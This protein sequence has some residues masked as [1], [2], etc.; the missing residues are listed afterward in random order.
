MKRGQRHRNSNRGQEKPFISG[1]NGVVECLKSPHVWVS[2]IVFEREIPEPVKEFI[3]S[4][5][6]EKLEPDHAFGQLVQQVGCLIK[7]PRWPALDELVESEPFKAVQDPIILAL[8]QVQD[9][10]NLGQILR[11]ADAAGVQAVLIT[12][13]R[14]SDL[15]ATVAQVSQGA[16]AW[17]PLIQV[18]NMSKALDYLKEVGFW[19]YGFEA[20]HQA[21]L[22]SET[23]LKGSTCLVFG[24][25]GFGIRKLVREHC[26]GLLR[27][28]LR[29]RISSLN[30]SAAVSAGLFEAV[31][32][33]L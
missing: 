28:P 18:V 6:T 32:Q 19:C 21:S 16:F 4:V 2:K 10:Q 31:R 27:L 23:N 22:W 30:V 1:I 5:P 25:E 11:T 26:D 9:P 33:R 12:Q 29:G 15:N 3:G 20:D 8:D 7:F 24:S 17:V 13:H 14:S